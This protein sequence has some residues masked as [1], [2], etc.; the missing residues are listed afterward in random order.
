MTNNN[1][2]SREKRQPTMFIALL[3]IFAMLLIVGIGVFRYLNS[4][5]H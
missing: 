3:P 4:L 5:Y 2:G 1:Q